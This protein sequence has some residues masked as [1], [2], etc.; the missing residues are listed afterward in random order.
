MTSKFILIPILPIRGVQ[1]SIKRTQRGCVN[2]M[3][4]IENQFNRALKIRTY[5][6]QSDYS[7]Y[8]LLF[9]CDGVIVETEEM[10]RLAYN[11]AFDKFGLKLKNGDSVSW[12]IEYYDILQNTVGGGKPK[13]HHYF[14]NE[15]KIGQ[16]WRAMQLTLKKDRLS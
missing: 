9:D 1:S 13:M 6:S 12:S 15:V 7:G 14:N 16:K 2:G 8:A 4:K 10:H 3:C 11:A 5:M